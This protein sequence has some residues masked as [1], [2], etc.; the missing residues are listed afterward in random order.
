[1]RLIK[2]LC[3]TL[4]PLP[5]MADPCHDQLF[6]ILA[7]PLYAKIPYEA[8]AA[9]SIGGMETV[10]HQ[11]FLSDTHSLIKTITP[12]GLPDTLFYQGG[13]Y[14]PDGAGGWK[15]LY[16]TDLEA[17][18]QGL[19]D[20]RK[21]RSQAILKAECTEIDIEGAA[22]T[23]ISGAIDVVPPFQSEMQVEYVI[24]PETGLP[25]QFSYAY[26]MNG[27]QAESRFEYKALPGLE[28]PTP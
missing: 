1:M 8:H 6:E 11:K 19:E 13:T 22:H 17:Y 5:V 24:N 9:G 14:H 18:E 7:N 16:E 15:L 23:K 12:A 26:T 4:L 25:V 3:L 28:L 10:T 27:M 21:G 20:T 2:G